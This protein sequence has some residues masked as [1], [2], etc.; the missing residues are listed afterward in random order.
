MHA[1]IPGIGLGGLFFVLSAFLMLATELVRT[2]QGRSSLRR[3][4]VVGLQS[5]I[6]SG[7]VLVT[8]LMLWLLDALFLRPAPGNVAGPGGYGANT[9]AGDRFLESVSALPIAA[10]PILGTL[11][12]LVFVLC[13]SEVARIFV[14]RPKVKLPAGDDG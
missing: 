7:I 9:T 12:L 5:A 6:A 10:A 13:L 8:V 11:A 4:R 1:G 14:R 2:F 3:W